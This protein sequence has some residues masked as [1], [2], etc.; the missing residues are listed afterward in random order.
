MK[1]ASG[2]A[3]D[4]ADDLLDA[5]KQAASELAA[6]APDY[7]RKG[8]DALEGLGDKVW[9]DDEAKADKAQD[10]RRDAGDPKDP[11]R[12]LNLDTPANP[13]ERSVLGDQLDERSAEQ[14]K[15]GTPIDFESDI[16]AGTPAASAKEPG[17]IRQINDA[18]LDAAAK[19]GL[20]AKEQAGK[21]AGKIGDVS[22][23][24]GAKVM[25][26]G[27]VALSKAA[28]KGAELKGKFDDFVDHAN[29]EADKMKLEESIEKAKRAGEQAEARA[30]AFDGKEGERDTSESTLDG[31]DS[32]FERAGRFADGDYQNEGGKDMTIK[33]NP[34]PEQKPKGGM[35]A[36]FEDAD[37]DGDSLIDDAI[38]DED[39]D[40]EILLLPE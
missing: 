2:E 15:T 29:V 5:T 10:L 1:H 8:K 28:E 25:Q 34:H 40:D 35:I 33:K 32:F 21:L 22:E 38:L 13:R 3:V 9:K 27:D 20:A 26:H 6:K 31:T 39:D 12:H 36:G 16:P 19:A 37:G 7:L 14:R 24:V 30:R 11:F 23:R 18:A 4:A 17:A